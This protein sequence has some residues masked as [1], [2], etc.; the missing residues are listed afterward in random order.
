MAGVLREAAAL[1]R[2]RAAEAAGSADERWMV[3][4]DESGGLVLA[5]FM[6]EEVAPDCTVSSGILASFAYP[7][8]PER[9]THAGALGS[10][11]HMAAL[12]PPAAVA[13][14]A[15]LETMADFAD[16]A[17]ELGDL[18]GAAPLL[19]PAV[20]FARVYLRTAE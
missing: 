12:D 20:R 11:A 4:Q 1:L 7:D 13:L 6:P 16:R 5:V 18:R 14:A 8:S 15:W 10:A 19:E 9:A 2:R 17:E 3:D